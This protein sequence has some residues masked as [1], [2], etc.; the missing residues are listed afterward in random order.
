MLMKLFY[1]LNESASYL[2]FLFHLNIR[3]DLLKPDNVVLVIVLSPH[4]Y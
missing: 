3:L 2:L 4:I 1:C